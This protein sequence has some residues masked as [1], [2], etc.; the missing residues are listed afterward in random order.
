MDVDRMRR[1]DAVLDAVLTR[2]PTQW[3]A[4]LDEACSGDA[5]LRRE[6]EDLLAR[7]DTASRFLHSPPGAIAAAL[8]AESRESDGQL[9]ADSFVGRRVGAYR[10]DRELGRGG[11]SR[12]FLAERADGEFERRSRSSSCVQ[13]WTRRSISRGSARSGRSS[14]R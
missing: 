12:V 14:P 3:P 5:E 6:V 9:G 8:V 2:E 10:M 4:L 13:G 7:L 1:V 11:M